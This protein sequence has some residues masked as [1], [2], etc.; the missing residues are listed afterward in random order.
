M[1]RLFPQK[2]LVPKKSLYHHGPTNRHQDG[3]RETRTIGET[4][5]QP[6]HR[7]IRAGILGRMGTFLTMG[8][9]RALA[10]VIL[11][12]DAAAIYFLCPF[13]PV[14]PCYSLAHD[15][16]RYGS[17]LLALAVL[18]AKRRELG[19]RRLPGVVCWSCLGFGG[20]TLLMGAD[21]YFGWFNWHPLMR[22]YLRWQWLR[23]APL[24][25]VGV[26][27]VPALAWRR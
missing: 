23:M 26:V 9:A 20:C 13:E 25:L 8:W 22:L 7:S 3:A 5:A 21:L 17:S 27:L 19:P 24:G 1:A 15:W 2:S 11:A 12:V 16:M 10:A 18:I 4:W 6:R 14:I